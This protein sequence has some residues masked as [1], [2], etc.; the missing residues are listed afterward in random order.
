MSD[1]SKQNPAVHVGNLN[2]FYYCA[3]HTETQAILRDGFSD[4]IKHNR[5]DNGDVYL[6]DAPGE[7]DPEFPDDQLLE[8]RLPVTIDL[9]AY[10]SDWD[11][12]RSPNFHIAWREWFVL[13]HILNE[14][15]KIRLLTR[16]EWLELWSKYKQTRA[17]QN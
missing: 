10:E 6:A 13:A 2:T 15:A 11:Q 1:L 12:V 3:S 7:P 17:Q 8:I 16:Q 5:A 4:I 14:H 9:S